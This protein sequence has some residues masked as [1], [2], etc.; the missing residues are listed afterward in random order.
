MTDKTAKLSM[1]MRGK[2][3]PKLNIRA[4]GKLYIGS[5]VVG[6]VFEMRLERP[7]E[8]IYGGMMSRKF[9]V[10]SEIVLTLR[11]RASSKRKKK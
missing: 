3:L 5:R 1:A 10:G 8:E 9:T 4:N 11:C 2:K 7:P 6:E